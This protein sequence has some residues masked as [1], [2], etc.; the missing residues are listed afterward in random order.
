MPPQQAGGVYDFACKLQGAIGRDAARIVHLSKA[1][2]AD[3]EVGS[4]DSVVLQFSGYGFEK[5]GA[6]WWLLQ[7][8]ES[9][10]GDFKALGIFFHELYAFGPPWT[11]S[12]WLSPAQRFVASELAKLS[13]FWLTNREGSAQW[14]RRHSGTKPHAV[15]PVFS[16]IGEMPSYSPHRAP[17]VVVFGGA[18]LRHATYRAAGSEL[19]AWARRQGLAIHDIGPTIG[20]VEMARR[21][22]LEGVIVHGRLPDSEISHLLHDAQFGLVAY[23]VNYVAK[24]GVFA[25]YCAHG[26]CPVLL[27][28]RYAE[29]DGLAP[30]RHYFPGIPK[31]GAYP[32]EVPDAGRMAWDWYQ[33][34]PL[35][36]H[37]L[38][39]SDLLTKVQDAA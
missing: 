26:V 13:D 24:S 9:R 4:D 34:H 18:T 23:P 28:A 38:T 37:F 3:W 29:A 39:L 8:F 30:H 1:N 32:M 31:G 17:K 36:H 19:F 16:N 22:V 25:A 21:L 14:L 10:R 12:F 11:S 20:D 7:A 6:P 33:S 15:L 27:S 5:R 2:V 35:K